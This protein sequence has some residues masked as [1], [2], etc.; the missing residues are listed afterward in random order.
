MRPHS[1]YRDL[2]GKD[3]WNRLYPEVQQR[4]SV[5]PAGADQILYRGVMHRVEL[6]PMGWL[7]AQVC[8]LFGTPLAPYRGKDI[9]MEIA[10]TWNKKLRGVTWHR[11]YVFGPR[12]VFTVRS[13]KSVQGK[14]AIVEHIGHGFSMRLELSERNGNLVF[15]STR[16]DVT[17]GGWVIRIPAILTPGVTTVTHE[18]IEGERFRFSLSVKHPLLGQ[19]IFQDGEFHAAST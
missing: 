10:L 8:R 4:F 1:V 18:Q 13:T 11:K 7:F 6:S 5:R 12:R 3:A 9:D 19:T 16:Y 15:T 14:S 17:I 2:L